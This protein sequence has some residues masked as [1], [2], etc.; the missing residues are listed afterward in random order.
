MGRT[1]NFTRRFG[2]HRLC[3]MEISE[4]AMPS[5]TAWESLEGTHESSESCTAASE[6]SNNSLSLLVVGCVLLML[7]VVAFWPMSVAPH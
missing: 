1:R 3:E 5:L 6:P 4:Q 2:Q 7:V